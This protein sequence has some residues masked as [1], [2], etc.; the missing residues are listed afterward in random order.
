MTFPRGSKKFFFFDFLEIEKTFVNIKGVFFEL[1]AKSQFLLNDIGY[2][3]KKMTPT[4]KV[5]LAK[6]ILDARRRRSLQKTLRRLSND[7]PERLKRNW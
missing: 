1:T 2:F 6:P 3:K 5:A 4:R 7:G